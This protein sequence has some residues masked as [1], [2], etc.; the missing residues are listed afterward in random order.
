M[1]YHNYCI[2]GQFKIFKYRHLT[3]LIYLYLAQCQVRMDDIQHVVS[4]FV[5][6][7]HRSKIECY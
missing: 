5:E 7:R 4:D 3:K 6:V 1:A 2:I